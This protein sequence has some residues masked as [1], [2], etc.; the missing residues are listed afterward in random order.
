[1]KTTE[2]KTLNYNLL[3]GFHLL[4]IFIM[5]TVSFGQ[6]QQIILSG[7]SFAKIGIPILFLYIFSAKFY[8]FK[9][10]PLL[11]IYIIFLTFSTT[12]LVSG[13]DYLSILSNFLGY[14]LLFQV[15]YVYRKNI[16]KIRSLFMAYV[17]GLSVICLLTLFSFFTGIDFG[18]VY[19]NQPMVD[20][21]YGLPVFLGSSENPNGFATLLAIGLPM[22]FG[23]WLTSQRKML[24]LFLLISLILFF[25]C[26]IMTF[27]RSGIVAGILGLIIIDHHRKNNNTF[28]LKL[29]FKLV[30][31]ISIVILFS[32]LFYFIIELLTNDTSNQT[33]T[34]I[35]ENK[36]TSGNYRIMVLL[37]LMNLILDNFFFGVGY[38]NI[39]EL[40]L[41]RVG[42]EINTHNIFF[43]VLL[44]FGIFCFI[45]FVS[46]LIL[47]YRSM[48]QAIKIS[49]SYEIRI[50]IS[51]AIASLTA[52]LF[53]GMFH[54]IHIHF[55]FWLMIS[56]SPVFYKNLKF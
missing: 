8:F 55:M 22:G 48:S 35:S 45:A 52:L 7:L 46:L 20:Y 2:D 49:T 9:I 12:S 21:W 30:S 41:Q 6:M 3:P 32:Y 1:M 39:P 34:S 19:A 27:S 23:L 47:S 37:P 40:M 17:S 10:N 31:L 56:I 15:I 13:N 16:F 42:L 4:M 25:V 51:I 43:E 14:L 11:F 54:A 24:S 5:F 50:L 38:G 28:S 33:S 44:S 36:E 29:F 53:H 18:S 26:L